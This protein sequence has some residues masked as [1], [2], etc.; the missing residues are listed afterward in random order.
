MLTVPPGPRRFTDDGG[1]LRFHVPPS[2]GLASRRRYPALEFGRA[3]NIL[4]VKLDF[5]GDWIVTT[6]FLDELRHRAPQARITAAVIDRSFDIADIDPSLDRVISIG[7]ARGRHASIAASSPAALGAFLRDYRRAKFDLAL[8]PCWDIDFNGA[9]QFA[10]GSGAPRILGFCEASTSRRAVANR[11]ENRFFTDLV[12]DTDVIHEADRHR[13]LLGPRLDDHQK[14]VVRAEFTAADEEYAD[15][16][17]GLAFDGRRP[18]LA[19]APL[20]EDATRTL[21]KELLLPIINALREQTDM[22]VVVIAAPIHRARGADIA[23]SLGDGAISLAGRL[24]LRQSAAVISRCAVLIGMD[25]GP[26]HIGAGVGTP[27]AVFSPHPTDSPIDHP[28]SPARFAPYGGSA[29]AL[30]LQPDRGLK[31]CRNGCE[32][33]VAHCIRQ[34]DWAAVGEPLSAFVARAINGSGRRSPMAGLSSRR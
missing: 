33:P 18:V 28:R 11:G 26:V 10:F 34:L 5:A 30:L 9:A 23:R 8:V 4:V 19:V 25:S 12:C 3:T 7:R 16:L 20:V 21:P 17:L 1:A 6:P 15:R 2:A 31:D 29:P 27:V 22:D 13:S 24:N 14:T 32:R